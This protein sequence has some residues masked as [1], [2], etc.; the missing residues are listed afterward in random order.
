MATKSAKK[1]ETKTAKKAAK[2][3]VAKKATGKEAKPAAKKAVKSAVTKKA[4]KKEIAKKEVAKKSVIEAVAK[5]ATKKA[6]EPAAIRSGDDI[7]ALLVRDLAKT[8][9]DASERALA[10]FPALQKHLSIHSILFLSRSDRNFAVEGLLDEGGWHTD[11]STVEGLQASLSGLE[12]PES[13]DTVRDIVIH[14]EGPTKGL[15]IPVQLTDTER[16]FTL[17]LYE[18]GN[19]PVKKDLDLAAI[20]LPALALE[21]QI[22]RTTALLSHEQSRHEARIAEMHTQLDAKHKKKLDDALYA[23]DAEFQELRETAH[24]MQAAHDETVALLQSE[25]SALN[26]RHEQELAK[27]KET[28]AAEQAREAEKRLASLR[29]ELELEIQVRDEEIARSQKRHTEE[30]ERI[31]TELRHERE[32]LAREKESLDTVRQKLIDD[33]QSELS[34]L[35]SQLV[36]EREAAV[37][38]LG[39]RLESAQS[40]LAAEKKRH[41]AAIT[42]QRSTLE[43][44]KED[45]VRALREELSLEIQLRDEEIADLKKKAADELQ[46]LKND[47]ASQLS[48]LNDRHRHE[49]EEQT[50]TAEQALQQSEERRQRELA[51]E[52]QKLEEK[53]ESEVKALREELTLEIQLR[54]EEIK[55]I[56]SLS[57]S[58]TKELLNKIDEQKQSYEERIRSLTA[59]YEAASSRA[60]NEHAVAIEGLK[61]KHAEEN[62][63]TQTA[64]QK[65]LAELEE[66]RRADLADLKAEHE[67]VVEALNQE[68]R[69]DVAKLEQS[70][71]ELHEQAERKAE[72]VAE[73]KKRVEEAHR[74]LIDGLQGEIRNREE[75]MQQQKERGIKLQESYE[76]ALQ[77]LERER[78]EFQ[79]QREHLN[80]RIARIEE[81][82]LLVSEE[83]NATIREREKTLQATEQ[84]LTEA[85]QRI[86]TLEKLK[87]EHTGHIDTLEKEARQ[88]ENRIIELDRNLEKEKE[89]RRTEKER[90]LSDAAAKAAEWRGLQEE[91]QEQ[92]SQKNAEISHRNDTIQ[93]L[94]QQLS[95]ETQR[96]H[97]L[98]NDLEEARSRHN[99][100]IEQIESIHQGLADAQ[101]ENKELQD[102]IRSK[103]EEIR[104]FHMEEQKL[105]R[106]LQAA[107][108]LQAD[109]EVNI[110]KQKLSL[111]EK[112]ELF[113]QKQ[114]EIGA[115]G[116]KIQTLQQEIENYLG[117]IQQ[118]KDTIDGLRAELEQARVQVK[119][120][121]KEGHLMAEAS[122]ALSRQESFEDKIDYLKENVLRE[123]NIDRII[124]YSI[125]EN[126]DLVPTY[127][128]PSLDFAA[129]RL[130]LGDTYFGQALASQKPVILNKKEGELPCDLPAPEALRFVDD[131]A[132]HFSR[133]QEMFAS[134]KDGIESTIVLPLVLGSHTEGI[135]ALTTQQHISAER[136][137][138]ALLEHLLPF[139]AAAY[140]D[141]KDR[142]AVQ[143][144]A[145]ANEQLRSVRR[146]IEKRSSDLLL[147]QSDAMADE[148]RAALLVR[149]RFV[150]HLLGLA[151]EKT[152]VTDLGPFLA[153]L[154][155]QLKETALYPDFRVE[156]DHV[157]RLISGDDAGLLL[158]FI[159][160]AV[161][162]AIEHSEG[163]RLLIQSAENRDVVS[164]IIEDDGEGLI[165]KTG[166]MTPSGDGFSFLQAAAGLLGLELRIGKGEG[167][168]GT[169]LRLYRR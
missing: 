55:K 10:I 87:Q 7:A 161:A 166:S 62:A 165:R 147:S 39:Q 41:E 118:K 120:S 33:H 74:S 99:E 77:T 134:S 31:Q 128:S 44:A 17:W 51:E 141:E 60:N 111:R 34:T 47:H 64:R 125:D 13:A 5:K 135:L 36:E 28:A 101:A 83:L 86:D 14:A 27:A 30:L 2:K 149:T 131:D 38:D 56:K 81:E 108:A 167:G 42:E 40:E 18:R 126:D 153:Q 75:Q 109:L 142:R 98:E 6:V 132:T 146:Y 115:L 71:Q 158:W 91:L 104:N 160:E 72:M 52:R 65:E 100:L 76:A 48:Q 89:E 9:F 79:K 164:L 124:F 102:L 137:D 103:N 66:K 20:V 105:K 68:H 12:L 143:T 145:L 154:E 45:A 22:R 156:S 53:R 23:K 116:E 110:E 29:E 119:N 90:L 155:T 19:N 32:E 24:R 129:T 43:S 168:L 16:L 130:R 82:S 63:A 121:R 67:L 97:Q 139:V 150:P 117:V 114:E 88:N 157:A 94:E 1:T 169:S 70:I 140:H 112:D 95:R 61:K 136:T 15:S 148:E 49:K 84:L 11:D 106:S 113:H 58:G 69:R 152:T 37:R 8:G 59:E 46:T 85:S 122:R 96:A 107:E 50:R 162:N 138:M 57:E 3:E 80:E 93:K 123:I 144:L 127:C 21:Y 78:E 73:E 35:R 92:L 163:R 133:Y 25:I 4:A 26:E 151:G 159:S 54:D